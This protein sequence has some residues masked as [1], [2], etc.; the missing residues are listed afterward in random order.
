MRFLFLYSCCLLACIALGAEE[1]TR[2][3]DFDSSGLSEIWGKGKGGAIFSYE[4]AVVAPGMPIDDSPGGKSLKINS[5]GRGGFVSAGCGSLSPRLKDFSELCFWLFQSPEDA[6]RNRA[7]VMEV[8][9]V[10]PDGKAMFWRAV[11]LGQ[12]GWRKIVLPLRFFR[13]S[14]SRVPQWE[15]LSRLGFYFR[16]PASVCLDNVEFVKSPGFDATL[17]PEE[18]QRIAF[19]ENAETIQRKDGKS[20]IVMSDCA[21][22]EPGVLSALLDQ[23]A[24]RIQ[25]DFDF[26]PPLRGKP[27]LLVFARQDD[28]LQFPVRFSRLYNAHSKE[29]LSGGYTLCGVATSFWKPELG[30]KRPVYT[31]EYVHAM[32]ERFALI[33]NNGEWVQEGLANYYQMLCHPQD[34]LALV[35][36]REIER[37]DCLPLENL[38]SGASIRVDDYWQAL[39]LMALLL[40]EPKYREKLPGLV[41]LFQANGNTDLTPLLP[42][43]MGCDWKALTEDWKNYCRKNFPE[44]AGTRQ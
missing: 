21:E 17:S 12:P 2:L 10:E 8:Q 38:C 16:G 27:V 15:K 37:K 14:N 18:L 13:A 9:L 29:P 43:A 36:S 5:P 33:P 7:T 44:G 3:F 31:H 19:P 34:N 22:L 1:R 25:K 35:I 40:N 42:S 20:C 39:S 32:F 11:P 28:Y 6:E 23:L 41:S 30:T 4:D 24:E 26:L